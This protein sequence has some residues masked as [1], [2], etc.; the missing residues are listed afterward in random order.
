MKKKVLIIV[1]NSTVP[2]DPRVW[3]EAVALAAA[4]YQVTILCP[5]GRVIARSGYEVRDGIHIYRHPMVK[6]GRGIRGILWEYICALFWEFLYS[7]WIYFRRGIDVIQACNPPDNIALVAMP[8]KLFGVRFIFDHHDA[9]PELYLAKY[10]RKGFLYKALL[11]M[12]KLTFSCCDTVIA[13][14]E[15]YR[16]I[17]ISR[18]GCAPERVYVV[19]NGPDLKRCRL[20]TPESSLKEG[21]RYLIGYV[22]VMGRQDGLDI[23]IDVADYIKKLGRNDIYFICVGGGPEL[24][25]LKEVVVQRNLSDTVRFTGRISD[26]E[27]LQILSTADVCVNPDRPCEMNNIST[28][29]KIME[30]MA[31]GKPI[32]QYD[33]KEGRVSAGKASLYCNTD[34]GIVDFSNKILW[35]L[36]RPSERRRMGDY[37]RKKV[38]RELAW[39]YS[40]PNL[41]RAYEGALGIFQSSGAK[42][43]VAH[44]E[45]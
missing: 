19:R 40:I 24:Q 8:F 7:S 2:G 41:L 9:S 42:D 14:N 38:E 33:F 1:E 37:G 10:E 36:D 26:E 45:Q 35:L 18:G 27:M 15:S 23:L 11:W 22:G 20:V 21:K 34:E 31:L 29:I 44:E 32:V 3:N 17:A 12:E 39:E 16:E 6:E 43:L 28:M 4:N 13:T 25:K 5:K 30:Y